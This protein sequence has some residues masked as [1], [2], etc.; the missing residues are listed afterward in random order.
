MKLK[1]P[2]PRRNFLFKASPQ[3]M[4][5]LS[6]DTFYFLEVNDAA[7]IQHGYS[8]DVFR[9]LSFFDICSQGDFQKG[10]IFG[11]EKL[12]ATQ[13]IKKCL[14]TLRLP[15]QQIIDVEISTNKIL[16][17]GKEAYLC[18]VMD[19]SEKK[20]TEEALRLLSKTGVV[21]AE[22]LDY[23]TIVKTA[24][25]LVLE[26]LA[27]ICIIDLYDELS[28]PS[29]IFK[30]MLSMH[31][32]L[33]KD[34]MA[35]Q[36]K[37]FP[38]LAK[39]GNLIYDVVVSRQGRNIPEITQQD[40]EDTE[41]NRKY[42][43]LLKMMDCHSAIVAPL[44]SHESV[45][46]V[47]S[48]IRTGLREAFIES[49]KALAEEFARR[50]SLA[51]ENARLYQRVQ[52]ASDAKTQFLANISHEIRTPLGAVVGFS[53]ILMNNGTTKEERLHYLEIIHR[54]GRQLSELIGELL[55]LSKIE[56]GKLDLNMS[57]IS[58][59]DLIDDVLLLLAFRAADK[60]L[61]IEVDIAD[62]VPRK[63]V[64]DQLRLKQI[65]IN[66]LGNAIKFSATGT[67]RIRQRL[68]MIESNPYIA[69]EVQDNG[70]GIAPENQKKLFQAFAQADNT[71]TRRFGGSG[72]GL[73]LSK[74][75]A[76]ALGG[77][78]ELTSSEVGQ[79]STFRITFRADEAASSIRPRADSKFP[80]QCDLGAPSKTKNHSMARVLVV[81]DLPDNQVLIKKLFKREA[82]AVEFANNGLEAIQKG[83][84]NTYD[85]IMMDI[86][87]PIMDGYAATTRL[88][89][90]GLQTPIVALTAHAFRE[91]R[92]KCLAAG[93]DDYIT[94]PIDPNHLRELIRSYL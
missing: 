41:I 59:R 52:K 79:G 74:K 62:N 58:P 2:Q 89:K 73:F 57:E 11:E 17:K 10:I 44:E 80:A 14:S 53:E 37:S 93:C 39:A 21:L 22:S 20:K 27:D 64:S 78:V 25:V 29:Q 26:S 69:I 90:M 18:L 19:I 56:S 63:L 45:F 88:R 35:A 48:L 42:F 60:C 32:D 40:H 36:L 38:P 31:R 70:I 15:S 7:I 28:E 54:N 75:L 86:Q 87:M 61:R 67:V 85:L 50:T 46:G 4:W 33:S 71:T 83:S 5:V 94:K 84:E 43:Q 49:D 82:I 12:P 51:I 72:L 77:D 55:D 47:I 16:Y 68:Q 91:D 8:I 23:E 13:N 9:S 6:A 76:Q 24:A 92:E 65:L 34:R 30:R 81:E 1:K 3:P 66:I